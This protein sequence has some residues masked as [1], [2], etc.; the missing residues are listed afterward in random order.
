MLRNIRLLTVPLFLLAVIL[1]DPL[2]SEATQQTDAYESV[3]SQLIPGIPL[4]SFSSWPEA[5]KTQAVESVVKTC[6]FQCG[7]LFNTANYSQDRVKEES[8]TCSATCI[9]RH[10]PDD[11]PD[12]EKLKEAALDHYEAAKT[13]GSLL[14]SPR[15]P[16]K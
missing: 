8:K 16:N 9:V 2:S 7:M 14:P 1:I 3:S 6:L 12:H 10:L 11:Y 15:F 5:T 4:G 13:L